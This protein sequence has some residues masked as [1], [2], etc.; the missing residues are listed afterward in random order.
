[1]KQ[2]LNSVLIHPEVLQ[3]EVR[4]GPD[5]L[6][7]FNYI[8]KRKERKKETILDY[9]CVLPK[10]NPQKK[11][12]REL[13]RLDSLIASNFKIKICKLEK[14]HIVTEISKDKETKVK[15]QF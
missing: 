14:P 9:D 13:F 5:D 7:E 1:M 2:T 8:L 4:I 12:K 6:F 10:F 15:K 11:E 3:P